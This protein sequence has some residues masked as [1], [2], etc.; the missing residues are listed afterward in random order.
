MGWYLLPRVLETLRPWSTT[1]LYDMILRV[2]EVM[3]RATHPRR[4]VILLTDGVGTLGPF[5]SAA[6]L[7]DEIARFNFR[8]TIRID[9]IVLGPDADVRFL[10]RLARQNGGELK[11][12]AATGAGN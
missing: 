12:V 3:E 7:A 2:P 11:G 4:A 1:A 10:E 9:A 8:R 6:D 5:S